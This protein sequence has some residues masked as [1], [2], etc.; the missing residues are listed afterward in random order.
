MYYTTECVKAPRKKDM[1][2]NYLSLKEKLQVINLTNEVC[3][4]LLEFYMSKSSIP[5]YRYS[6][7]KTAIALNW[8]TRKVKDNRLK[9]EKANLYK[10]DIYGT[11]D[12]KAIVTIIGQAIIDQRE[13]L[14]N[15]SIA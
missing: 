15:P 2:R 11:G 13:E 9:L 5:K 8:S 4:F 12:K 1:T 10:T 7:D 14:K 3:L 6:D